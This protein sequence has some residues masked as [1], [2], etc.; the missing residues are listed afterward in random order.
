MLNGDCAGRIYPIFAE[1]KDA[2][3]QWQV[4]GG[5]V[6]AW[7]QLTEKGYATLHGSFEGIDGGF[8]HRFIADALG[9]QSKSIYGLH[10]KE[11]SIAPAVALCD[12]YMGNET[13]DVVTL[14]HNHECKS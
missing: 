13:E 7:F 14:P 6:S 11:A 4:G 3:N 8:G 1:N 2:A 5:E 10:I 9:G 12:V